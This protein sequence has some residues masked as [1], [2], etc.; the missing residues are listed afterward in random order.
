MRQKLSFIY[1][2]YVAELGKTVRTSHFGMVTPETAAE[3]VFANPSSSSQIALASRYS[4]RTAAHRRCPENKCRRIRVA[5]H[6]SQCGACSGE[7]FLSLSFAKTNVVIKFVLMKVIPV[8]RWLRLDCKRSHALWK[9]TDEAKGNQFPNLPSAMFSPE[10][11]HCCLCKGL[12]PRPMHA[13]GD[14]FRTLASTR[15]CCVTYLPRAMSITIN[16]GLL[17]VRYSVRK[18][19]DFLATTNGTSH[20]STLRLGYNIY[21]PRNVSAGRHLQLGR[22]SGNREV[23]G[24]GR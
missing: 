24:G 13:R 16:G 17:S 14:Y 2:V 23:S 10:I 3:V 4:R 19:T 11:I 8:N 1:S 20:S 12:I 6:T 9:G 22:R 7:V 5:S 21:M 18:K 15:M